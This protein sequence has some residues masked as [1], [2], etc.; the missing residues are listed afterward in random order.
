MRPE[1]LTPEAARL[2]PRLCAALAGLPFTLAGGTGLALQLGHRISVDFDWF[3]APEAFPRDLAP[4]LYELDPSL[5]TL[6]D[7]AGTFECLLGGVKCSFFGF[8]PQFGPATDVL[9]DLP[10]APVADI[11]AM[12]LI[13]VSQRGARKDFYDL[14]EVL[15]HMKFRPITQ[16][17]AEMYSRPSPNPVHLAKSLV[18]FDDAEADPEPR[19][20]SE[21]QWVTVRRYF[22]AHVHEF[23]NLLTEAVGTP[24]A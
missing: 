2:A 8:S 18:Y 14:H 24:P 9:H 6:Q 4:R 1:V 7:K 12:K 22:E 20:L 23:T 13:A 19:L 11:A 17:L 16:R 5:Q 3:C 15:R 21:V 10:L